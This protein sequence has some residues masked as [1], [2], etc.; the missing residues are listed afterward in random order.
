MWYSHRQKADGHWQLTNSISIVERTWQNWLNGGNDGTKAWKNTKSINQLIRFQWFYKMIADERRIIDVQGEACGVHD[1]FTRTSKHD[2]TTVERLLTHTSRN[3]YTLIT[4]TFLLLQNPNL[5]ENWPITWPIHGEVWVKRGS[6][7]IHWK[8]S[9][10]FFT[11]TTFTLNWTFKVPRMSRLVW[12]VD[13]K[14]V[15]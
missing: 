7:V 11:T 8:N 15:V 4:H 9:S 6:T 14:S 3:P 12:E 13:R 1:S 10:F 2:N 5:H